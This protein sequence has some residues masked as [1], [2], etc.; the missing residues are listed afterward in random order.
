VSDRSLRAWGLNRPHSV[1][2]GLWGLGG[3]ADPHPLRPYCPKPL[4]PSVGARGSFGWFDRGRRVERSARSLIGHRRWGAMT[5]R[6]GGP[7]LQSE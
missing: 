2:A 4:F 7:P 3:T 6:G 5:R 1:S